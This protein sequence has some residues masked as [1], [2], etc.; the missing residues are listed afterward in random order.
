MQRGWSQ[1]NEDATPASTVGHSGWT[2]CARPETPSILPSINVRPC[3]SNQ[4]SEGV[5]CHKFYVDSSA[6][7]IAF[8]GIRASLNLPN[9]HQ[10]FAL[11]YDSGQS[12]N[13]FPPQTSFLPPI[14]SGQMPLS[15]LPPQIGSLETHTQSPPFSQ[16]ELICHI[17]YRSQPLTAVVDASVLRGFFMSSDEVWTTYRRAYF[18]VEASFTFEHL[19]EGPCAISDFSIAHEL[20][21]KS[22]SGF[23]LSLSAK[24]AGEKAI[25][26][27]RHTSK[28]AQVS[29][30]QCAV[31]PKGLST[32]NT[33]DKAT[34]DRLQFKLP[35]RNNGKRR[36]TQQYF[37]LVIQLMAKIEDNEEKVTW[38]CIA[39]SQSVPLVVRGRTPSHYHTTTI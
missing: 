39:E 33:T 28:R 4:G 22:I 31:V 9:G 35:T 37:H 30:A 21:E 12:P 17:T 7:E 23:A 26:L 16:Q 3:L 20:G 27:I 14:R 38:V 10:V 19:P 25:G 15:T 24:E 32:S 1:P 18:E 34:W 13:L 8:P 36:P 2:Y 5:Q 29:V 6:L 11:H